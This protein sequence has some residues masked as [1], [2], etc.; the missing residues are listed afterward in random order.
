M[1]TNSSGTSLEKFERHNSL[2][3][4][5]AWGI[6]FEALY[7][8]TLHVIGFDVIQRSLVNGTNRMFQYRMLERGPNGLCS[9]KAMAAIV[10]ILR[11]DERANAEKTVTLAIKARNAL[12]H[13][14]IAVHSEDGH[15]GAGHLFIKATQL[16][17]AVIKE[18]MTREAAYYRFI[19]RPS[20]YLDPVENWLKAEDDIYAIFEQP[21]SY[22]GA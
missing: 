22:P 10:G 18:H 14:A 15:F 8:Q 1:T 9:P 5:L 20:D 4:F 2:I 6:V 17:S 7:R 3:S 13:G 12:S 21:V 19:E 11:P 16:L